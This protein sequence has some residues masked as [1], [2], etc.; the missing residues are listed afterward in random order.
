[1]SGKTKHNTSIARTISREL[2]NNSN[3][4]FI[5]TQS[6]LC[7]SS[8]RSVCLGVDLNLRPSFLCDASFIP[9]TSWMQVVL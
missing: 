4:M 2:F 8:Y 7:F 9:Q 3:V 6:P 5:I 1:M